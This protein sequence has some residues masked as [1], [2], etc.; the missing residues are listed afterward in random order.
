MPAPLIHA[1]H[2]KKKQLLLDYD[3]VLIAVNNLIEALERTKPQGEHYYGLLGASVL[4][5]K[6][7]LVYSE[8]VKQMMQIKHQIEDLMEAVQDQNID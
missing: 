4:L 8:Q 2:K 1:N 6:A 3:L 5:E 7:M